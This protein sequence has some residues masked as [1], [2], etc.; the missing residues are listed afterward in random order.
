MHL[1]AKAFNE[2]CQQLPKD[3]ESVMRTWWDDWILSKHV[4]SISDSQVESQALKEAKRWQR[5]AIIKNLSREVAGETFSY[6]LATGLDSENLS[7]T[8]HT[9]LVLRKGPLT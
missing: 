1:A 3:A 7:A 8:R 4:D 9:L 2:A 6:Q 5:E